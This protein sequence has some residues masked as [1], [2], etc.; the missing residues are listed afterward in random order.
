MDIDAHHLYQR[1]IIHFIKGAKHKN[2]SMFANASHAYK[3]AFIG[4]GRHS[5]QGG[6]CGPERLLK[7]QEKK[8]K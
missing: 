6:V 7:T 3:H 1:F 2:E 4:Q 5:S 8:K